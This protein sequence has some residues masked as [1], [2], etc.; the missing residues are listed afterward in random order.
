[1]GDSDNGKSKVNLLYKHY[2]KKFVSTR[3]GTK[4]L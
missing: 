3:L 2:R 1:M 4:P